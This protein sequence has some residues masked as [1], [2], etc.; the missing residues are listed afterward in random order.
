MIYSFKR[1]IIALIL[2]I[3]SVAFAYGGNMKKTIAISLDGVLDNHTKYTDE[4][5]P[6]RKGA[7]EFIK[8]LSKDYEL[9]LF[10]KRNPKLAKVWLIDNKNK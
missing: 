3:C 9:I 4:I 10:T 8:K 6:I 1:F 5:P 7:K 2:L